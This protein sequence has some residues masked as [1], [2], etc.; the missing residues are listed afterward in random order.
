M[1]AQTKKH[2]T[3]QAHATPQPGHIQP[4]TWTLGQTAGV[5]LVLAVVG[6]ILWRVLWAAMGFRTVTVIRKGR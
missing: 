4:P 6:Y 3:T 2:A 5:L 1:T